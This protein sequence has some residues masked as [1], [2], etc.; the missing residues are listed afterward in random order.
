MYALILTSMLLFAMIAYKT[1]KIGY[2]YFKK[3]LT[4]SIILILAF[5]Y[6]LQIAPK[7]ETIKT[8]IL[9][10]INNI[11]KSCV[12]PC[13]KNMCKTLTMTRG[14]SYFINTPKI[15]QSQI[16]NCLVTYWGL[17]H[18]LLYTNKQTCIKG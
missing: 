3:I 14:E 18:F 15:N 5:V 6:C 1:N 9:G 17:T 16:K 4:I 10:K 13:E 12:F 11:H 2:E 7:I 8:G